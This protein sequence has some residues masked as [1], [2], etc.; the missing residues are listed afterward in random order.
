M[1]E[2]RIIAEAGVNHDG[3]VKKALALVD[4]ALTAKADYIKFQLFDPGQLTSAQAP[5]APYQQ[6]YGAEKGTYGHGQQEMLRALSLTRDEVLEVKAYC[7]SLGIAFTATPF[8]LG[9][10]AFLDRELDPPFIKIGSGDLTNAPL[11]HAA[12]RTG[13]EVILSTG[14]GMPD[15]VALAL[16]V[17]AHGYLTSEIPAAAT[18][19][20]ALRA[21]ADAQQILFEKVTLL[22]CTTAY[23]TP[24]AEV[25][26]RAL[27]TLRDQFGLPVG[28]SDHTLGADAAVA[29]VALGARV[30]EKHFT[31]DKGA[32]GPDHSASLEPVELTDFVERL[33][34]MVRAMGTGEKK[35]SVG[36][37]ENVTAARRSLVAATSIKP[38]DV[39][40]E[41]NLTVKRPSG[42]LSPALYW[43]IL[44]RKATKL[45]LPDQMI[46]ENI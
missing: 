40:T 42:G 18:D 26:L 27:E 23:P 5:L 33:H 24:M 31:L 44:G 12:A 2:L 8:D 20:K 9:N 4:T 6:A 29:A 19:F 30:I 39:F 14:M 32:A 37:L 34:A 10:L 36:E 13:R 11:L 28:Y 15:E 16:G 7:D 45:Y 43:H 41:E 35:P 21:T 22:H 3:D 46:E 1:S 17:L 38:G 25:N